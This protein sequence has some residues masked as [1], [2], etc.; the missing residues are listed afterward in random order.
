MTFEIRP[1]KM[2]SFGRLLVSKIVA[3]SLSGRLWSVKDLELICLFECAKSVGVKQTPAASK[4]PTFPAADFWYL[5]FYDLRNKIF[6]FHH[7]SHFNIQLNSWSV[8]LNINY[9]V[10]GQNYVWTLRYFSWCVAFLNRRD[11]LS[12]DLF[13]QI[14]RFILP[15]MISIYFHINNSTNMIMNEWDLTFMI[16][17][18]QFHSKTSTRWG[19]MASS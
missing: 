14:V 15:I 6:I 5:E 7:L 8:L 16:G 17:L 2:T 10:R 18:V 13:V 12:N 4:I 3:D 19:I 1:S 11:V 9:S